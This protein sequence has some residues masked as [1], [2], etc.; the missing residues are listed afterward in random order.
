MAVKNRRGWGID[1]PMIFFS[2]FILTY[3]YI[4]YIIYLYMYKTV[5]INNMFNDQ[6]VYVEKFSHKPPLQTH[7]KII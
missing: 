5:T 3:V 6:I 4:P 7:E 2:I 1:S